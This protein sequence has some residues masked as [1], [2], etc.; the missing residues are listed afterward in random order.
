MRVARRFGSP[1]A[2]LCE[3][4]RSAVVRAAPL[5]TP[6]RC[7]WKLKCGRYTDVGHESKFTHSGDRGAKGI[8]QN[9]SFIVRAENVARRVWCACA[10]IVA[11]PW[12]KPVP[13]DWE[14]RLTN[15]V[16]QK[17]A[18]GTTTARRTFAR[19]PLV[20]KWRSFAGKSIAS[21]AIGTMRSHTVL[22]SLCFGACCAA[23]GR[24][25]KIP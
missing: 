7:E 6:C 24:F 21:I 11:S 2:L 19:I 25:F 14:I 5:A 23:L 13:R 10:A 17:N 9:G 20:G 3:A 16:S 12:M 4:P 1:R 18:C 8:V 22:T 15:D